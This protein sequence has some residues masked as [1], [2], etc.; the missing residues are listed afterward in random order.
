MPD[1][2]RFADKAV[3]QACTILL[4]EG[5]YLCSQATMHR[6]PRERGTSGDRR[7]QAV[8]PARKKPSCSLR[9]SSWWPRPRR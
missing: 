9:A 7:A 1:S 8:H 3:A 2:S 4:D 5:R 6:L